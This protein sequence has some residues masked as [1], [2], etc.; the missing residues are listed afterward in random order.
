MYQ[1]K[2]ETNKPV[3]PVEAQ[4]PKKS[5]KGTI[6]FYSCYV[7]FILV[8]VIAVFCLLGPLDQWL[9]E[10]EASQP[11]TKCQIVFDTHFAGRNWAELYNLAGI[12]DTKYEGR[13]DFVTY[14]DGKY[15]NA[16]LSYSETS[17]GL[18]GD[19]KYIVH[20]G[21]DKI[22]TFTLANLKPE[23][24]IPD[25]S[26]GK[27]E[28]FFQRKADAH[29]IMR[30]GDTAYVNGIPLTDDHVVR[31][32]YTRAENYLPEG[33]HGLRTVELYVDGLLNAPSITV[34]NADGQQ[35]E[36]SYD[37]E[38]NTY[39]DG[40]VT[41]QE[42]P[43]ELYD[44]ALECAE[45]ISRYMIE[46]IRYKNQLKAILG[47]GKVTD[48]V[49]GGERFVNKWSS[50]EF[51]NESCSDY[52]RYTDDLFSIH[53]QTETHIKV[54]SFG[55][56]TRIIEQDLTLFFTRDKDGRWIASDM[57]NFNVQDILEE[58]RLTFMQDDKVLS[59]G[60]V[61]IGDKTLATPLPTAPEGKIFAGWCKQVVTEE[62]TTWS[63]VFPATED[64]IVDLTAVADLEP[65]TLYPLFENKEAK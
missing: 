11:G 12:E 29:I 42:A 28:L 60:F 24:A 35:V 5:K 52:Y 51:K 16:E 8:F 61:K 32:T 49:A 21:D 58:V 17:A 41:P 43:Q 46:D 22:A 59:T 9:A 62:G 25:W 27:V 2:Y 13:D 4:E 57:T 65:M 34:K 14:M 19:K 7:A 56:S 50:F 48:I 3:A 64:G 15:A 47:E 26:L 55:G 53:V 18:S 40:S 36:L 44:R 31:K 54:I 45:A 63:L 20:A 38:S 6:V 10:F 1:G 33:V 39:Y 30:Q 37:K 23:D